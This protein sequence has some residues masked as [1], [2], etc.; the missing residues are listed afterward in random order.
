MAL[1]TTLAPRSC[2]SR[3]AFPTSTR[4]FR[5]FSTLEDRRLS[6]DAVRL[7]EDVA[8]LAECRVG[9]DRVQHV[10]DEVL[11][12]HTRVP[13]RLDRAGVGGGVAPRPH[14]LDP[15][16]LAPLDL[17]IDLEHRD[18][19]FLFRYEPV[20]P[21]DDPLLALDLPLELV[22]GVGD[23]LLGISA[24]DRGD[25][26]AHLVDAADVPERLL[27]HLARER[28]DEVRAA[29]RIRRGGDTRLVGE[30]LLGP[31]RDR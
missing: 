9:P 28:L 29:Q 23:L 11:A 3:P 24:L 18:G 4:I 21:D 26:P 17:G 27:F 19:D 2:P 31:E 12:A 5:F 30:D 25:D 7:A 22:G 10:R 15:L 14:G 16:D 8:D 13:E 1:A 6:V 20:H